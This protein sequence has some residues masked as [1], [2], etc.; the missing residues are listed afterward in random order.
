MEK[1]KCVGG[2][3]LPVIQS[4][5]A[6]WKLHHVLAAS[7]T[8][9]DRNITSDDVWEILIRTEEDFYHAAPIIWV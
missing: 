9:V 8:E 2:K 4:I 3:D 7:G 5:E 6:Q 1:L